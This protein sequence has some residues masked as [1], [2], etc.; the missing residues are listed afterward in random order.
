MTN[1][2]KLK[3]IMDNPLLWIETFVNIV[4]KRGKL[5]P[6]KFNPQQKYIMNNKGKFNICL[7]S[8]QLGITSVALAYSL[9]LAITRPYSTCMIMAYSIDS[10]NNIFEKLK[11]MYN[12]LP[13]CVRVNTIANNRKELKFVNHSR[14]IV[15]TCGSKDNARGAT[16]NF[17]HLSEVRFMN[18][19]LDK[20][21]TAIE[22]ALVSFRR[23]AKS[24]LII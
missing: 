10:V 6:F 15:C 24:I 21:L 23:M 22:Q 3:I 2:E 18:E 13:D 9:Y 5:V 20:Q 7:K 8:R 11:Q 17:V 14:I 1:V 12:D 19:Y 4:D 16:L